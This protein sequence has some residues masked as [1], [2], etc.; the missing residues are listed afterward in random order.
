LL[1][2][3]FQKE[4]MILFKSIQPK[5]LN[6]P[7][8][9]LSFTYLLISSFNSVFHQTTKRLATTSKPHN[10]GVGQQAA[11]NCKLKQTFLKLKLLFANNIVESRSNQS[12]LVK[13]ARHPKQFSSF[14]I[15]AIR[16][17]SERLRSTLKF[18]RAN[19]SIK[20]N[21]FC[22]SLKL[23]LNEFYSIARLHFS[24][25]NFNKLV[26]FRIEFNCTFGKS[27]LKSSTKKQSKYVAALSAVGLF[28]WDEYKI[29]NEEIKREVNEILNTFKLGDHLNKN[30]SHTQQTQLL[31]A[32]ND[33]KKNDNHLE[34]STKIDEN[35]TVQHRIDFEKARLFEDV[36]WHK[37]FDKKNLIVWRRR[38]LKTYDPK[39]NKEIELDYDLFEY[40]V[41]GRFD[42]VTP[43]EFFKTQ[44]DLEFRKEWDFLVI[45]IEMMDKHKST[46]TELLRWIMRFPYPLYPREYIFVR[47]YCVEPDERFLLLVSRSLPDCEIPDE[48]QSKSS[49]VSLLDNQASGDQELN[50]DLTISHHIHPEAQYYK[51]KSHH[52]RVTRYKSNMIVMPH[53]DFGDYGLDYVIQ[54]YD[55]SKAR[56]PKMAYKWMAASGLPEYLDKVHKAALK[57]KH[58]NEKLMNKNNQHSIE[59]QSYTIKD[60]EIFY[61]NESIYEY[62]VYLIC[63][64]VSFSF[65]FLTKEVNR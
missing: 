59:N 63:S 30:E 7:Q 49:K 5:N 8:T 42:D 56:I 33:E 47:R 29:T 36:E 50:K 4:K 39:S 9:N 62:F 65:S 20:F 1:F 38:I 25:Y 64:F 55:D 44:I 3:C 6:S 45:L 11:L 51:E 27:S 15:H 14:R 46:N 26:N 58:H 16:C 10:G 2:K 41:L 52:V 61:M 34:I 40:K 54:Y 24:S 13:P 12:N 19:F 35:K 31:S 57:L 32:T 48:I 53:K 21:V 17:N 60:Y 28:S 22:E 43:I 23:K 18:D 37:I